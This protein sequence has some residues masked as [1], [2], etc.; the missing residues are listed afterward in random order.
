MRFSR[1]RE[2]ES[3]KLRHIYHSIIS[4]DN[5]LISW[6]EFLRGK[7]K[8]KDVA[9]FSLNLTDNILALHRSLVDKTYRH[10]SYQAFKINDPKPREIHKASVRD[11]LVHHAIYRVLYSYFD[12][13]FI[14]DSYSYR[15]GKGTHR[16]VNGLRT[17]GRKA[18]K[19]NTQTVWI[20]KCDIKKFFANINHQILKEIL[21]KHI[22]DTNSLWLLSQI[23]DSFRSDNSNVGLPLGN[24]TSQLLVNIYMNEFDQY[25]KRKLK[26]KYYIRYADDFVILSES[27]AYLKWILLRVMGLLE[28]KLKLTLHPNKITI[29]TVASGV[30]YLGYI[31]FSSHRIL[32]TKTK[33]RM[34]KR[35]NAKNLPS[36]L[37]L[38][39]HCAGYK[40]EHKIRK[41]TKIRI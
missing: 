25:A 33:R 18:S 5:L 31:L 20:L 30:D 34:L 13:K 21:E 39:K 11:R 2:R 12:K 16:A 26:V 10:G 24:L 17:F 23:T 6:Q 35:V 29:A 38:L 22:A 14:Y 9:E 1:E 28:A 19:N 36:Y 37:G 40:L 15:L 3:R 41:L 7:R 8:R 27:K 4:F 32:R